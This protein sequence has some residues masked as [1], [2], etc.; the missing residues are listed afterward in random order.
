ML[1]RIEL[2]NFYSIKEPVCIDFRAMNIHSSLAKELSD[3]VIEWKGKKVLK[4]IGLFGPNASGK[5]NIIKAIQFCCKMVLE[6]HL[7][8]EGTIFNYQP[9]KFDGYVDRPSRFKIDFVTEN[10]EYEYSFELTRKEILKESL[11]YYPKGRRA[12]I[13][14]RDET[15]KH[16]YSFGEGLLA[17]PMDVVTNTSRKNLFLSRASSMN[18]EIAKTVYRFFLH[19]FM[20]GAVLGN[21]QITETNFKAYKNVILRAMTICDTDIIDI[22][23]EH[24]K[25]QVQ[26]PK[27]ENQN[28]AWSPQ[29]QEILQFETYHRRNPSVAFDMQTEESA[30]TWKL[31]LILLSLLDVVQ[32]HKSLM[33]DEFDSSLHY[34]LA[35]FILDLVHA[36]KDSQLLF[37]SHDTGL[38]DIHRF[39]KDQIWFVNKRQDAST[40]IYSLYDYKDFRD[41]MDAQ[42]A[43]QQG[44]FDAVSYVESSVSILKDLMKEQK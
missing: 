29:D 3:N 10:I 35:D 21:D 28:I 5:S 6:S 11:Y 7:H 16:I 25:V 41:N 33:L 40:E 31:F 4:S 27:L 12:K 38:I 9:F 17:R 20:L 34:R 39:R 26:I 43:Y 24:K 37:T 15:A 23:L 44:R 19:S 30:G 8:N 42:K 14:V 18:R 32:N 1:L 13:F 22:R 36:S 2:S